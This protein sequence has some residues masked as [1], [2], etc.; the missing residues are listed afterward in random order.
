M[1]LS[2]A[3]VARARETVARLLDD[4]GLDAYLFELEPGDG[5][6]QLHLECAARDGWSRLTVGL[7]AEAVEQAAEDAAAFAR[8]RARCEGACG[9]CKRAG[10]S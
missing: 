2:T 9:A 7:D 3:S 6:W 5:D 10:A 1:M 8:L 4:M